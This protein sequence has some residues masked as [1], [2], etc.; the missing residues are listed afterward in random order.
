MSSSSSTPILISV[1][2][3]VYNAQNYIDEC[4]ESLCKQSVQELEIICIDD[5]STDNSAAIIKKYAQQ[6]NR[7]VFL[8]QQNLGQAAA[9]NRGIEIARGEWI[10]GIDADDYLLPGAYEYALS[11][12]TP[13]VDMVCFASSATGAQ[14]QELRKSEIAYLSN[15]LE[16][17]VTDHMKLLT[18]TNVYF[19]N[20]LWRKAFLDRYHLRFNEGLWY[21]DAAFVYSALPLVKAAAYGKKVVHNYRIHA[22]STMTHTFNKHNRV[23]EHLVQLEHILRFYEKKGIDQHLPQ[24]IPYV[25]GNL[26]G[27]TLGHIHKSLKQTAIA[28]AAAIA[29]KFNLYKRFPNEPTIAAARVLPWYIKPF[30]RLSFSKQDYRF[31]FL[32]LFTVKYTSDFISYK[33]FGITLYKAPR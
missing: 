25:F 19:W 3:P 21:E 23:L 28:Q 2:V 10:T 5:G 8:S 22:N 31:L 17:V 4:L 24:A 14:E 11:L 18:C 33:L 13:D 16:G 29:R 7:I 12:I 6:D 20:K 32:P 26:F 15:T 9:R 1:I 27:A 30:L